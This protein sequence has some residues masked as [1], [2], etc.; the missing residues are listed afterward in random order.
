MEKT[1]EDPSVSLFRQYLRIKSVHPTPNYK[2]IIEFLNKIAKEYLCD[3]LHIFEMV[4]GKPIAL[5]TWKGIDPSLPSILLN[6]HTDVVPVVESLWKFD[7][8]EAVKDE[9]GNIFARGTQDMKC[10]GIQYLEAIGQIKKQGKRLLRTV[11]LMYVPDEEIGG[12]DGMEKFVESKEFND[13]NIAVALDEGLASPDDS[14]TVFYGERIPWWLSIKAKGP[15]GHGSRF[16]ENTAVEKLIRIVNKLLTFRKN[17]FEELQRG[18]A[19]C[20]MKLGDVTTLNLTVLKAGVTSDGGKSFSFNVIPT[21]AEAGFDIRIPPTVNLE[22]FKNQ[23]DLWTTE[24]GVTYEFVTNPSMVHHVSTTSSDSKWWQLFKEAM[25]RMNIKLELQVFPA[26]TDSRFIRSKG[27]PAFG[28][29]P[30]N[31]TPILLHDHNEFLNEN[32]FLRGIKIYV[33]LISTLCNAK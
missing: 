26:A 15:T 32:I 1:K 9:Q 21:E 24:E 10:V 16:I 2:E 5:Y 20:G 13:L 12:A 11:H 22:E 29:S 28:F 27:I 8:F 33:D 14:M 30:I 19:Q 23:L 3:N 25:D 4:T 18:M 6:S 17:Q 31:N 7:P